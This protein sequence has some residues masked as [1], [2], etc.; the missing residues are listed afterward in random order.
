MEISSVFF[1]PRLICFGE[2]NHLRENNSAFE[3]EEF[4]FVNGVIDNCCGFSAVHF[5]VIGVRE[6]WGI[7]SVPDDRVSVGYL[8]ESFKSVCRLCEGEGTE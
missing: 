5:Q 8:P 3:R 4:V 6:V 2:S 1:P 7:F